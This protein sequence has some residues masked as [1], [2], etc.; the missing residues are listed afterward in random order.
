MARPRS[1]RQRQPRAEQGQT[2]PCVRPTAAR[3]ADVGAHRAP[4]NT[5]AGHCAGEARTSYSTEGDRFDVTQEPSLGG[6]NDGLQAAGF[7]VP[8]ASTCCWPLAHGMGGCSWPSRGSAGAVRLVVIKT[9]RPTPKSPATSTASSTRP[10]S[11]CSCSTQH[12]S[13][14]DVGNGRHY[15]AME[16]RAPTSPPADALAHAGKSLPPVHRALRRAEVRGAR[17]RPSPPP[18]ADGQALNVVHR[19][20][21]PHN[22]GELRAT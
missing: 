1:T 9:L 8:S 4:S 21:S 6:G 20:V 7:R 11:S 10:A 16:H 3:V 14:V 18:S 12:L 5:R 17:R 15:F 19:D 2:P 13:G 22:D